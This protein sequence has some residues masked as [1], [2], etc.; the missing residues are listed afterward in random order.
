MALHIYAE[1]LTNYP[2]NLVRT[3]LAEWPGQ[4]VFWPTWRELQETLDDNRRKQR[5]AAA[6]NDELAQL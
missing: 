1:K 5:D 6:L 3:V 4:H 2:S